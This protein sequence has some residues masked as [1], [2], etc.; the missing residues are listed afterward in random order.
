MI[1]DL[2]VECV[3][4]ETVVLLYR[5]WSGEHT[6]EMELRQSTER[7]ARCA[8]PASVGRSPY[9]TAAAAGLSSVI[10]TW[11]ICLYSPP[12]ALFTFIEQHTRD[13]VLPMPRIKPTG[14]Q[15]HDRELTVSPWIRRKGLAI[16]P[17]PKP[18]RPGANGAAATAADAALSATA[19]AADEPQMWSVATEDLLAIKLAPCPLDTTPQPI[20][21]SPAPALLSSGGWIKRRR[22]HEQAVAE[23]EQLDAPASDDQQQQQQ[24]QQQS[25]SPCSSEHA[26]AIIEDGDE[27][28]HAS[29]MHA[30]ADDECPLQRQQGDAIVGV[31]RI[32]LLPL[33]DLSGHLIDT[34]TGTCFGLLGRQILAQHSC[35]RDTEWGLLQLSIIRFAAQKQQ[36]QQ[37]QQQHA[38]SNGHPAAANGALSHSPRKRGRSS[39]LN[40]A[41]TTG[42]SSSNDGE[43]EEG[44]SSSM[45]EEEEGEAEV[46]T[47]VQRS[48][49]DLASLTPADY[50]D[51]DTA[52]VL[53]SDALGDAEDGGVNFATVNF[54]A[55]TLLADERAEAALLSFAPHLLGRGAVV[56]HGG[57]RVEGLPL[58]FVGAAGSSKRGT[59]RRGGAF[60]EGEGEHG[61]ALLRAEDL[62]CGG[63]GGGE[64]SGSELW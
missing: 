11:D 24:Q 2:S 31:A 50:N 14:R 13:L 29:R 9:F 56:N 20:S 46:I 19:L 47:W 58:G 23:D 1:Q 18:E 62:G 42:S 54:R 41:T 45:E 26:A 12:H 33:G 28:Q 8:L 21:N 27:R 35:Y 10:M 32:A 37:Q 48:G 25:D 4:V 59:G 60:G 61:A 34:A 40:G 44:G 15:G 57:M 53:P 22:P 43:E 36:Q 7:F 64:E 6:R 52:A 63:G 49:G 3:T 30:D 17:E 39:S 16:D 51:E 5:C 55:E 38:N